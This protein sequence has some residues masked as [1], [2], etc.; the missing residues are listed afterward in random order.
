MLPVEFRDLNVRLRLGDGH[1]EVANVEVRVGRV[2]VWPLTIFVG[3][4]AMQS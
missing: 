4:T 2:E 3:P 1:V